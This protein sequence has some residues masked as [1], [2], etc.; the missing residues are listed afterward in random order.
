MSMGEP[1]ADQGGASHAAPAPMASRLPGHQRAPRERRRAQALRLGRDETAPSS[2][3]PSRDR[4]DRRVSHERLRRLVH[5][6][7]R[8]GQEHPGR[9]ARGRAPRSA[10]CTSRCSTATRCA[11]TSPKGSASRRRIATPTFAASAS[12]RSSSRAPARARSPR[13]SAPTATSATSSARA[14]RALLRGVLP[15]PIAALAERDAKGLYKKALAGEIKHFT[16]VDDPYEAP[17]APEVVVYTDRETKEESLAKILAKL[18]ELGF[19][20]RAATFRGQPRAGTARRARRAA[21]RRA[22]RPLGARRRAESASPRRPSRSLRSTLDERAAA[23]VENIAVG[24]FS[25][26]KGFMTSKDYLRVVREMR[27]ENG[28]VW[29]VPITLAVSTR[30]RPT[31]SRVGTEVALRT[32][33]GRNCRHPRSQRQVRRPTR[34]R[35][36]REV[37]RTTD[38]EH[39]G[40]A[41]LKSSGRVYIGG[42]IRVLERPF[43]PEFPAY[44]R[45]PAADARALLRAADGRRVVGFQTR[46]PMHRAHEYI[47][48]CALEIC[49][50]L[51]IHPLVGATKSDDIPAAVRMSCY[52]AL[53]E[54][55]LPEGP[56]AALGVS[57][58]DALRRS[59]RGDLSRASRARTTAARIS[60]SGA[61]TPASATYYGSLRRAEDLRAVRAGR[62]RD[63][64]APLR[65]RVLLARGS[66]MATV[67]TAPG[68]DGTQ[69]SLSGT[70]V[71]EL[72][73]AGQFPPPEFS[74]PEVAADPHGFDEGGVTVLRGEPRIR[75][76]PGGRAD[77]RG[78]DREGRSGV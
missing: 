50:G 13:P 49:D 71:R 33:D 67:K 76:R 16:G 7:S 27:L 62:A 66:G 74:R 59:A 8:L 48:K 37:Y 17:D 36:A 2:I 20:A 38:D 15:C 64:P 34:R 31:R 12:W 19:I 53:L 26:L 54:Q 61:I 40:V 39:P 43:A 58:G 21:R 23:D 52:E 57:G 45:D 46:N 30:P 4:P 25:P 14:D 47:T 1:P 77:G 51:M 56:G 60:S 18:E 41:Y 69:V 68:D 10:A 78:V 28:L 73:R 32:P 72:L 24:A 35:E 6:L 29:S 70:K 5:G 3:P 63:H 44:H 42:E 55:L 9:D 75:C 22:R 65:G 11:R